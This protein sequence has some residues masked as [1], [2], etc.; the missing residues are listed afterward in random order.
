MGYNF[1]EEEYTNQSFKEHTE[2]VKM[3]R[4]NDSDGAKGIMNEH[5][6]RSMNDVLTYINK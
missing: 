3:I 5:I 6:I 2:I 1:T 4:N